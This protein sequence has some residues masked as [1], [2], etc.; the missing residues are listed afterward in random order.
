[1]KNKM[2]DDFYRNVLIRVVLSLGDSAMHT[3]IMSYYK[4]IGKMKHWNKEEI[5][6]WQNLKLRNLIEHAYNNVPYYNHIMKKL[7]LY[8]S[9]ITSVA[10]LKKLPILKKSDIMNAYNEFIPLNINKFKFK[11]HA[12]GGSTG[13]PL[14]FKLDLNSWSFNFVHKYKSWENRGYKLG[15]KFVALGSSSLFPTKKKSYKH[16]IFYQLI[17]KV[18]FNGVNVSNSVMSS[19]LD[20][21]YRNK[22][23]YIYGYASAIYSLAKY[24][25]ESN[26]KYL[27]LKA[28]FTTSETL[29]EDYRNTIENVF[30][31]NVVDDYGARD[32]GL[33]AIEQSISNYNVAYNCIVE[34]E[35]SGQD[36]NTGKILATDLLNFAFPFIRYEIGD[37]VTLKESNSYNGQTIAK[38]WGRIPDI[39]R[40]GNGRVLT[41]PGFTILFKDLNVIAYRIRKIN[42]FAIQIEIQK[43]EKYTDKEEAL[44][45]DTFKKH[46]G[47]ECRIS[48]KY[49]ETFK[50]ENS[51]KR[52]YFLSS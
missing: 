22:I 7:N 42:D 2:F 32:G 9:D 39:I 50:L 35:P 13:N 26:F 44:I 28:C 1:M 17:G 36:L 52:R 24:A 16:E 11:N 8:P 4:Q 19:Y 46:S 20:Y 37:E 3:K 43:D 41:G 49:I 51:G 10:D 25:E 6:V 33:S 21:I 48:I 47:K 15:E 14:K 34:V 5:D 31:C 27:N 18:P 38:V 12:T 40:L 45:F 29:T 30:H 23:N